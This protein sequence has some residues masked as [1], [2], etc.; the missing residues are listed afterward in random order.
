MPERKTTKRFSD[1][2]APGE[3][4]EYSERIADDAT[5]EHVTVRFYQGTELDVEVFPFRERESERLP[6]VDTNGRRAL[7]GDDDVFDFD[8]SE[9]IKQGDRIGVQVTNNGA[10]S[11]DFVT[12]IDVDF[13]GGNSRLS[14]LLAGLF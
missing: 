1:T 6:L 12:D 3:S 7:V 8:V 5:A 2:V 14:S 11:Y 9:E 4:A 10:Y 13:Q